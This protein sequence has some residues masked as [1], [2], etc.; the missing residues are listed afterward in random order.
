MN[1]RIK[2]NKTREKPC[3]QFLNAE[4][5]SLSV[6]NDTLH[7]LL[8]VSMTVRVDLVERYDKTFVRVRLKLKNLIL[9][10]KSFN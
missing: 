2:D 8:C 9:D 3:I 1:L 6:T 5:H 10:F 7:H 4:R